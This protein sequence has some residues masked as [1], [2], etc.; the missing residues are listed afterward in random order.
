MRAVFSNGV[1]TR[2][3]AGLFAAMLLALSALSSPL[4]AVQA[5][6]TE[7]TTSEVI[8]TDETDEQKVALTSGTPTATSPEDLRLE[9]AKLTWTPTGTGEIE[10][11]Y[12]VTVATKGL[13]EDSSRLK[14]DISMSQAGVTK[15]EQDIS[16]LGEGTYY[17]QVRSCLAG[18]ACKDWSDV[19]TVRIDGTAPKP[20]TATLKS[21]EYDR[22]V[23]MGGM[24]EPEGRVVIQ[25]EELTCEA[26]VDSDGA[27]NCT[28]PDDMEFGDYDATATI[29][30]KAGNASEPLEFAFSVKELFVAAPITVE[31]LPP[32]LEVVPV[33]VVVENKV[34]KQPISVIDVVN[35][36]EDISGP[37]E[38]VLGAVSPLSTEGGVVQASESGWQVLGMPWYLWAGVG[39]M[40]SAGWAVYSGRS[41]RLSSYF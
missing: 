38:S 40:L 25:V 14:E 1:R 19:Y 9:N 18:A 12:E 6:D 26:T 2:D 33:S 5:A 13:A 39:G 29:Y 30:D 16:S 20:P 22:S 8:S 36:G 21:D 37:E 23:V 11:T 7:P 15:A 3:F 34:F 31:E 10:D 24:A 17:W 28:F 32:A 41:L 27:W 35:M 4:A